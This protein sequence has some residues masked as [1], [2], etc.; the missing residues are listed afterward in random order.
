MCKHKKQLTICIIKKHIDIEEI[1]KELELMDSDL[2]LEHL[3]EA[4]INKLLNTID[5]TDKK[6]LLDGLI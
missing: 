5:E 3:V 2:S 4:R 1:K 6:V